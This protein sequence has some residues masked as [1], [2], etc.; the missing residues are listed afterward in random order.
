MQIP[1]VEYEVYY[2]LYDNNELILL[3]I[4]ICKNNKIKADISIPVQLKEII[5]VSRFCRFSRFSF[6]GRLWKRIDW[7]D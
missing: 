5:V 3:D 6:Y 7:T 4:S 2:P 1:F